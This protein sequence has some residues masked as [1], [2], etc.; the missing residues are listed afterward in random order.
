[1]FVRKN[2]VRRDLRR[3]SWFPVLAYL[4]STTATA[5]LLAPA[6]ESDA[7]AQSL[8]VTYSSGG[9]LQI[10]ALRTDEAVIIDGHL[11]DA[12][13][14]LAL[15]VSGFV[16]SEP[17]EGAP[18]TEQT[19]VQMA[20]D[21]DKLYIAA[22]C[23]DS[24]P[25]GIVVNDIRE[26]FRAGNQDSFEVILDTFADRRNGFVFM[27]N[28]AGAR[29]DQQMA[30]EGREVNA[31]WDAVWFV[32]TSRV[33]DGWI[34][35][36]AIPFNSLRFD[37]ASS[38][39]WGINFSRRIRRRNEV[40]LWSPVPR[41]FTLNRV[42]LAGDMV[43]L[44]FVHPGRDFRVK[45][46]AV[47]RT[48]RPTGG[49]SFLRDADIGVDVKYGITRALTLDVTV[50]P[51]FAQVEADEQRVNLT[52]FSQFFPEKREFFLEN[53]GIFYVGDA[54]RNNRVS[55]LSPRADT[56][57]LVF[58]SRRIGLTAGGD[59]IPITAGVR[60][61]GQ[62]PGMSIG[63]LTVQTARNRAEPANNFTVLRV[64]KNVL[65]T[66]DIGAIV[67]SRQSMDESGDYNRVYGLDANIRFFGNIDWS[68]YFLATATPGITDGRNAFRSTL[69]R[70]GNFFHIKGG[71]MSIGDNFNNELGFHRR[72][73]VR[74][75]MLDTGIR[76]RPESFQRR[77][78]RE[79]HPHIGWNVFTDHSGEMV[80]KKL[81]T[82]YT[83]FFNNGGYSQIA[84]NPTYELL[85]KP[86]TIHPDA[87]PIPPG[88]Y[89]WTTVVA[90]FTSDPSRLLSG[91]VA[92]TSGGLWSGTQRS[93]RAGMALKPSF[94]SRFSLGMTRTTASLD[95]PRTDFV[96]AI[97]TARA[98]YSFAT[99]MFLDAFVQ[100]DA[101][102]RRFN[103]NVR[104][105]ITYRPLSDF[106]IVYNEQR[107]TT[108]E[109][110]IATGRSLIVK[111]TR[112]FSF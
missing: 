100:Y 99:N 77:G 42:S 28:P 106:F 7:S 12:V 91:N 48:V 43:G 65:A 60:M 16:Q 35:E 74:K 52:Q 20:Y 108:P 23:H 69:N 18:A 102:R 89:S 13:W 110:P 58:F 54:A 40:D 45:P 56:D 71:Y 79:M 88:G 46:Y 92:V 95:V 107:F 111:F 57:L 81:H 67:M 62:L 64:R 10:N 97:W 8:P 109:N 96:T 105:N 84:I 70:E 61:T 90:D 25:T 83:F 37:L 55:F 1:M 85:T 21:T 19:V 51:D 33:R 94:N 2:S 82:G 9:R 53:S 14:Q 112:M 101:A 44:D 41:A 80:S 38:S 86:F 87:P 26:D 17:Q 36:M 30:N 27:T 78:I 11:D 93:I 15:P 49:E 66:S 72:I 6:V 34:V 39:V 5:Q 47:G 104:F 3:S 75:Y 59:P 103:T 4:L 73:G 24:D 50:N 68:T 22:Y 63:A 98:N 29:S 32:R 31:S 76:P